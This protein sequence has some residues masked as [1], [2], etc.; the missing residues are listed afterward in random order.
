MKSLINYDILSLSEC[1]IVFIKSMN[2][3]FNSSDY[4]SLNSIDIENLYVIKLICALCKEINL[5]QPKLTLK[6]LLSLF[7]QPIVNK[8]LNST[9]YQQLF[10][11]LLNLTENIK[12]LKDELNTI[13]SC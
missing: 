10:Q 12:S 13:N 7:I 3:L 4:N 2:G 1:F 9:E 11:T 8:E 5:T 6:Y